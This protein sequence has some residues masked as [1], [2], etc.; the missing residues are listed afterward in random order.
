MWWC[1]PQHFKYI[2]SFNLQLTLRGRFWYLFYIDEAIDTLS[3][4]TWQGQGHT[5]V[6]DSGCNSWLDFKAY[7]PK[8]YWLIPQLWREMFPDRGLA[9]MGSPAMWYEPQRDHYPAPARFVTILVGL[10]S[11]GHVQG[12]CWTLGVIMQVAHTSEGGFM[13]ETRGFLRSHEGVAR[14]GSLTPTASQGPGAVAWVD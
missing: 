7:F 13:V 14:A 5:M 9:F 11:R 10:Q 3:L 2:V 1:L 4:I 6:S 12:W 8:Y